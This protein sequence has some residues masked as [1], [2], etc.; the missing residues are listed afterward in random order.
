VYGEVLLL[1]AF[2]GLVIVKGAMLREPSPMRHT[3][4]RAD[5]V[6]AFAAIAVALAV[7]SAARL[8]KPSTR[9]QLARSEVRR[10]GGPLSSTLS[11][12]QCL[13]PSP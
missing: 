11:H 10:G 5:G 12:C 2:V 8:W 4:P 9:A 13:H 1:L 6:L 3:D 7:G